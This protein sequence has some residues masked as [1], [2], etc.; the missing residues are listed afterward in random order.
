MQQPAA[1]ATT[2][3]TK[4]LFGDPVG[5]AGIFLLLWKN[6]LIEDKAIAHSLTVCS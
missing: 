3:R 5:L 4:Y 2:T 6:S 1:A